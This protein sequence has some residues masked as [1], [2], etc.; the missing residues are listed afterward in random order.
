MVCSHPPSTLTQQPPLFPPQIP[1][2]AQVF[3]WINEIKSKT[4]GSL[5]GGLLLSSGGFCFQPQCA[6]RSQLLLL[7]ASETLKGLGEPGFLICPP[8]VHLSHN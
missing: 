2:S 7:G 8:G 5:E 6:E 3:T 1:F 4:T